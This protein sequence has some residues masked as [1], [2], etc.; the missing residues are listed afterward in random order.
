MTS[1]LNQL[2]QMV[3][4]N[5]NQ[6]LPQTCPIATNLL[7]NPIVH[8]APMVLNAPPQVQVQMR[9]DGNVPASLQVEEEKNE[10]SH[11]NNQENEVQMI[12]TVQEPNVI[13]N[14]EDVDELVEEHLQPKH[15]TFTGIE[16]E[17]NEGNPDS[18]FKNIRSGAS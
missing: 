16:V 4:N 6:Q 13:M 8:N 18:P 3:Q 11:L 10:L 7:Q 9:V 1:E 14:Q 5:P 15:H 17:V 12:N 2:A